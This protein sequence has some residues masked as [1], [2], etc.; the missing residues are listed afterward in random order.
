MPK[1]SRTVVENLSQKSLEHA[2]RVEE[3]CLRH[4]IGILPYSDAFYPDRLK[5]IFSP[6][7][8]LYYKG[9]IP[10]MNEKLC[11]GIV[12][13]RHLSDYGRRMA[14]RLGYELSL[15][16]A[17]T[18]S[19]MA[20]GIDTAGHI[21]S[22]D[23]QGCTVAVMG[24]G[25]DRIYP[26]ENRW[27]AEKICANGALVSEY[28]PGELPARHHFPQRNRIISGVSQ[29]ICVVEAARGSGSPV[30]YTHLDVYKRQVH[31]CPEAHRAGKVF[32]HAFIFPHAFLAFF[33][34][35]GQAV[36]FDL[37]FAIDTKQL[38]H[39]QF[40]RQTVCVPSGFAWRCV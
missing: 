8:L 22:L 20:R 19:G 2:K 13:T 29:G 11:L 30:S 24:C 36:L 35:R 3:Y 34:K 15:C 40:H 23:A 4:G 28:P 18:V 33:N 27:L 14:Y 21:G 7:V 10:D 12:G 39:F 9:T 16:G 17:Y 6:P 32:P 25:L 37:F 5:Q 1:L 38:F 26:P 31:V